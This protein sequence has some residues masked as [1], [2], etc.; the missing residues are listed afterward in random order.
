MLTQLLLAALVV[1]AAP[2]GTSVPQGQETV[3]I[4]QR[5]AWRATAAQPL[6]VAVAGT[7]KL[8]ISYYPLLDAA[9]PDAPYKLI[10]T[11]KGR[12]SALNVPV[13]ASAARAGALT[14]GQ[15][16]AFALSVSDGDRLRFEPQGSATGGA[17]LWSWS[18]GGPAAAPATAGARDAR[19]TEDEADAEE[20][21]AD[22][23]PRNDWA[24]SKTLAAL[25]A[26]YQLSTGEA[27][28]PQVELRGG[29]RLAA[30]S[31]RLILAGG[32]GWFGASGDRLV[33]EAT[34]FVTS[35]WTLS[36]IPISLGAEFE[37]PVGPI[38]VYAG[39]AVEFAVT[40]L[41]VDSTDAFGEATTLDDTALA[42]G[43]RGY[44]GVRAPAGPGSVFVEGGYTYRDAMY[45]QSRY[46]GRI[47]GT[48]I[49]AGYRLE[50]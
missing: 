42:I 6:E 40:L 31:H 22:D 7:G 18:E 11:H 50:M 43:P 9:R 12:R 23:A 3:A 46:T 17:L 44:G 4:G 48:H 10:V 45:D 33:R 29:Y 8:R 21:D 32:I 19:D 24:R 30:L 41:S 38:A 47:S 15:P 14:I 26:G 39:A 49:L 35:D 5:E 2:A 34:G 37:Q 13:R 16:V 36:V 28:G 27:D 20:E 1:A 25:A